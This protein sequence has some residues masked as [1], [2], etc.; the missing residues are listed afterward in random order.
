MQ[1][2]LTTEEIFG[3]LANRYYDY[4]NAKSIGC[5]DEWNATVAIL[6][7]FVESFSEGR[8]K[9]IATPESI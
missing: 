5:A 7:D 1:A 8:L 4:S 9:V 3:L 2:K 6:R